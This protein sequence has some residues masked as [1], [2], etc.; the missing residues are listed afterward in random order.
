MVYNDGDISI[1]GI[2]YTSNGTET[3]MQLSQSSYYY[4][5]VDNYDASHPEQDVHMECTNEHVV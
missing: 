5:S 1:H 3:I 2:Y 4:E